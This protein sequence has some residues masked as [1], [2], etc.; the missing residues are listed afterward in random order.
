MVGIGPQAWLSPEA[1]A[2]PSGYL[3]DS[4]SLVRELVW[5]RGYTVQRDADRFLNPVAYPLPAAGAYAA[6]AVAAERIEQAIRRGEPMCVWGDFDADGQA[7]TAV[8]VGGLRRLGAQVEFYIPNRT[9]DSH[10]L[11]AAGLESLAAAG[12]C[13]LITCDC[14]TNDV[15]MVRHAHELGIDVVITDHHQQTREI[16]AAV[17][18]FNSS[19]VDRHDPIWGVPGV[20]VAFLVIRELGARFGSEDIAAAELDLVALGIIADLAPHSEANR[21][22]L[23][24]GLPRLWRRPRPGVRALL[25]LVGAPCESLD[26]SR[27]SYKLAPLLNAA[28]RLASASLGVELLLAADDSTAA[29]MAARLQALNQERQ[30]LAELL[31]ADIERKIQPWMLE[32][33]VLFVTGESWHT[34][35]IGPAASR[36]ASRFSRPAAIVTTIPGG[37]T[38]RGS[39]RSHGDY[40]VLA[41]L[42]AQSHLLLEWGGHPGAA[43]FSLDVSNLEAF[44]TGF[45]ATIGSLSEHSRNPALTIDAIVPWSSIRATDLGTNSLYGAVAALAPFAEGNPPPVLASRDLAFVSKRAFGKDGAYADI[46]FSDTGG[47]ERTVKW[48]HHDRAWLPTGRYDVAYTM[49]ADEW[50]GRTKVRLT[51]VAARPASAS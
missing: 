11:N 49:T 20:A 46:T 32:S 43:G 10:G 29:A 13:L 5:R 8:L 25:D 33:P 47:A 4:P 9:T 15:A 3:P 37:S 17:A 31:E 36:Y 1:S 16:P 39:V 51:L 48:W 27:I 30:H 23:A 44:Q 19:L 45:A 24:Q 35:L 14:G 28:G 22:L 6:L 41:A 2:I 34:G 42:G 38:A 7:A 21:T 40:D 12:C 18:L 26:T 50:Q